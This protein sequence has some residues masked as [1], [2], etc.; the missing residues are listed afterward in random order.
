VATSDR[1]EFRN[2]EQGVRKDGDA[3][4]AGV[5]SALP[6]D[7]PAPPPKIERRGA[8]KRRDRRGVPPDNVGEVS[9]LEFPSEEKDDR[10]QAAD[11]LVD[12][13]PSVSNE[14]RPS[15]LVI[16]PWDKRIERDDALRSIDEPE[17]AIEHRLDSAP[18]VLS[19]PL[20][21][22][23]LER[24]DL[25]AASRTLLIWRALSKSMSVVMQSSGYAGRTGVTALINTRRCAWASLNVVTRVLWRK[26][27]VVSRAI[28]ASVGHVKARYCF[29][30]VR[31]I[32]MRPVIGRDVR[33]TLAV[34]V[35][36]VAVGVASIILLM[37]R[38]PGVMTFAMRLGGAMPVLDQTPS[39][40]A[41]AAEAPIVLAESLP[42]GA[43]SAAQVQPTALA[44]I[45][46]EVVRQIASIAGR[47]PVARATAAPAADRTA[48]TVGP[49]SGE[50]NRADRTA[51]SRRSATVPRP[52]PVS[53]FLGSLAVSSSPPGA[54]VF[55]NGVPVG[56]TPLLLSSMP[57]GS[58]AVRVELD[59]HRRW[60]SAV[61][62][63]A[64][65]RTRVEAKLLP[66]STQ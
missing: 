32:R 43:S 36:G 42:S 20:A 51:P 61:R 7:A 33:R 16:E 30:R 41:K 6:V 22:A 9:L 45:S 25:R 58:R 35:C 27:R 63:V 5:G 64:D 34:F 57:V 65:E 12:P 10:N 17:P 28:P 29:G 24:F 23:S 19:M 13:A 49:G 44:P 18:A 11:Q 47:L 8:A 53:R 37:P 15:I 48:A 2:K 60:S 66:S 40:V 4:N 21:M 39:P 55:V 26:I 54:Q 62:I 50:P 46:R 14:A 52:A 1:L 38:V 3:S 59:G 56:L 31:P